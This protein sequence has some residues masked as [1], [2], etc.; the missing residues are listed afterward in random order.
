MYSIVRNN[1]SEVYEKLAS[2][3]MSGNYVTSKEGVVTR[4]DVDVQFKI[5]DTKSC[6]FTNEHRSS[7]LN[8]ISREIDWYINGDLNPEEISKYAPIWG[9]IKNEDGKIYSNYGYIISKMRNRH[10]YNSWHWCVSQMAKDKHTRKAVMN[11]NRPDHADP[12][13]KDYVCG[14][15][16]HFMIRDEYLDMSVSFRSQ[17]IILGLPND[18]AFFS[19]L[20]Q[21]MFNVMRQH[22]YGIKLG[23]YTHKIDSLHVYERNF[24]ELEEMS[25]YQF[26]PK[27]LCMSS[28]TLLDSYGL[29]SGFIKNVKLEGLKWHLFDRKD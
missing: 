1:F 8:Y 13:T 6:L 27:K 25:K 10:G 22:H 16:V 21:S 9:D 28:R 4:E 7:K 15:Y 5:T 3:L 11:I 12:S 24:D 20:H 18:I 19:A 29:P 2:R 14:M 17:D 23:S 26:K